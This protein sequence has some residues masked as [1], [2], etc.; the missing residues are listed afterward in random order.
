MKSV[1]I[2]H[3]IADRPRAAELARF[4]DANFG[5]E[6]SLDDA[7][8]AAN[9]EDSGHD[10][11]DATERALSAN[12]AIVLLSP[13]SFPST[14]PR[15]Q[16]QRAFIDVPAE[17]KT[18]VAFAL[19]AECPFPEMLRRGRFFDGSQD[20]LCCMRGLKRWI[21][22][23][24]RG[25]GGSANPAPAD[26]ATPDPAWREIVDQPGIADRVAPDLASALVTAARHDFE[27]VLH[28]RC[29]GRPLEIILGDLGRDLGL[30]LPGPVEEN[31]RALE[32][33]AMAHRYLIVL[34][35]PPEHLKESLRFGGRC[36]VAITP[37]G[38]AVP[39]PVALAEIAIANIGDAIE[40]V[41]HL[42]PR[43]PES[44][45]R[46]ATRIVNV[47]S[48]YGCFAEA[49]L[50]LEAARHV[51]SRAAWAERELAW[52]HSR[53]DESVEIPPAPII[54]A[55]QLDLFGDSGSGDSE[56]IAA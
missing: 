2:C 41:L 25:S 8:I 7:L 10:I 53:W 40:Y 31:R 32:W 33:H 11:L 50:V 36:S 19:L 35:G 20:F 34:D 17:Y 21:L 9:R 12:F 47:L 45:A 42:F 23:I 56:W 4:L 46:L 55:H 37:P 39:L 52:I 15:E 43:E 51:P 5:F 48:D 14:L 38:P 16:W 30:K 44:A 28:I 3:A 1:S 18:P 6:I 27:R 24:E 26:A 22:S 13:A 49:A 54:E 29:A